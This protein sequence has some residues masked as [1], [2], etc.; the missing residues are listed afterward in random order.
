MLNEV[1]HKRILAKLDKLFEKRASWN[2]ESAKWL[3]KFKQLNDDEKER[4]LKHFYTSQATTIA[5]QMNVLNP[6]IHIP[7]FG[8]FTISAQKVYLER[9]KDE[10]KNMSKKERQDILY[11]VFGTHHI[12]TYNPHEHE[13]KISIKPSVA[14]RKDYIL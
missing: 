7:Y 10:L 11:K 1:Q 9:H 8:N 12:L 3:A 6:Y 4:L 14:K 2:D 5:K 13:S